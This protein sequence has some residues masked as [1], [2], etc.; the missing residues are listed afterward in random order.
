MSRYR[1]IDPRIWNDAK[2]A[3]LSDEG[4]LVFFMLLT[5]P[6]MTALGAMRA[7]AEGLA[8][9]LGWRAEAFRK[10]FEE[11][12]LKGMAEHDGAAHF[13]ALPG[14]LK[15]NTPESPNVIR[16]W[17]GSVDLLPECSLK[18][19]V[20]QRAYLWS[21]GM[22]EG[23]RKAFIEAFGHPI[24]YQEQEQEQEPKKELSHRGDNLS[25]DADGVVTDDET[26]GAH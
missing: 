18:G 2:F 12:C 10:A 1:K 14:F 7:T 23:F 13:V 4:K 22:S 5:H 8:A 11:V 24:A 20:L 25:V 17:R 26:G 9:E 21:Q 6:S 15:Y 19:V 16:A 3:S